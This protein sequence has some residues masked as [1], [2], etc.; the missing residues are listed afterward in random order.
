MT[1]NNS[2]ANM[3]HLPIDSWK[4]HQHSRVEVSERLSDHTIE[5]GKNLQNTNRE[6]DGFIKLLTKDQIKN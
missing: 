3:F 4:G 1:N 6:T 5:L 2:I